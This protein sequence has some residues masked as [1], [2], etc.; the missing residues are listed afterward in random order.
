MPNPWIIVGFLGALIASFWGGWHFGGGYED[1][2][3]AKSAATQ[4]QTELKQVQTTD[5]TTEKTG[6]AAAEHQQQ[7]QT[8]YQ[9][10]TKEVIRYVPAKA[11]AR[12]V[13]PYGAIRVLDA[14]ARGVPLVPGPSGE[15]DG[16]ASG[17][18][19]SAVVGAAAEDLGTAQ[20]IRQQLIDLQGWVRDRQGV[21]Q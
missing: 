14:A 11:D 10:I 20:Q 18:Q 16:D 1:G 3:I 17:V 4:V 6:E 9:T 2:Q 19:L 15:P 13:I 21:P 5:L 8:V 7:I 12:C